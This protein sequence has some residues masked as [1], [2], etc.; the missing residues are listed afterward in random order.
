[1][2]YGRIIAAAV[3]ALVVAG[4]AACAQPTAGI[5]APAAAGGSNTAFCT[6][7]E[8]SLSEVRSAITGESDAE[9]LRLAGDKIAELVALAP[10]EIASALQAAADGFH[11]GA[12]GAASDEVGR[13]IVAAFV[14]VAQEL[15]RICS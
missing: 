4:P 13:R 3:L 14:R 6:A 7:L 5:P 11:A 9:Q 12:A 2:S 10:P 1:M 15:P 8:D